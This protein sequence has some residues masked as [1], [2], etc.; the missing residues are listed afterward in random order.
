MI[1][2]LGALAGALALVFLVVARARRY[3]RRCHGLGNVR[4]FGG[5]GKPRPCRRCHGTGKSPH[6]R[7]RD[8]RALRDPI[9]RPRDPIAAYRHHTTQEEARR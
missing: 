8:Q 1:P 6:R 7:R 9:H 5:R 2:A 3:C 4:R